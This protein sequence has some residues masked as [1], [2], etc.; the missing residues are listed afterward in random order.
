MNPLERIIRADHCRK[1][2]LHDEKGNLVP[3]RRLLLNGS[4]A[5]VTAAARLA[6]GIR[7]EVPWISYDARR[8]LA[9]HLKPGS[10]VLEFGSGMST[11][12]LARRAAWVCSLE[13]YRPWYEKVA[14]LLAKHS[15]KN[16]DYRL[17]A[18]KEEY[19][20][21]RFASPL[22]L[23]LILVDGDCRSDCVQYAV[24][25]LKKG[26]MLY[27]DNSD[28]D[29]GERGGDVRLAE[30]AALSFSKRTGSVVTYF[31]DFAPTQ[32]TPNQGMML[33]LS[34]GANGEASRT[35]ASESSI[36]GAVPPILPHK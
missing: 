31:T 8:L 34:P 36:A 16:V 12:W 1:T 27:L 14:A 19:A 11:V 18:S 26:G 13:S 7:P 25:F 29:S 28:K 10:Q 32:L 22:E 4:R 23:D 15:I 6:L 17:A 9:K 21:P 35:G 30:E 3:L 24:Q 20:S 5:Y 2:R 33:V